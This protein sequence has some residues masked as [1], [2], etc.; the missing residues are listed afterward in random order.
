MLDPGNKIHLNINKTPLRDAKWI[1][2]LKEEYIALIKYIEL[3]KAD[4]ND[5]FKIESNKDGTKLIFIS[6]KNNSIFIKMERKV[7]VYSQSCSI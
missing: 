7:L 3:N 6:L 5:W 1:E 2:R 4:D